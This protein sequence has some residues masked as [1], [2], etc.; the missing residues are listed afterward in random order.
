MGLFEFLFPPSASSNRN[1]L[2]RIADQ[3]KWKTQK[4]DHVVKR[5]EDRIDE[6]ENDFMTLTLSL[7]SLLDRINEKGLITRDEVR[8]KMSQLDELDGLKD[9]KLPV[10]LLRNWTNP[11]EDLL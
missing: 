2:K 4:N 9:G 7:A 11:S 8:E 6:L 3:Q 1:L 10:S 5:L